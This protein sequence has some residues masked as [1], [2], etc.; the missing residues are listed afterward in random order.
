MP[1]GLDSTVNLIMRDLLT[2]EIGAIRPGRV[3]SLMM[4][5]TGTP[6]ATV[7][8]PDIF[9]WCGWRRWKSNNVPSALR[10]A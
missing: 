10:A 7:A 4:P 9:D 2:D 3:L 1:F 5:A 8:A 6:H